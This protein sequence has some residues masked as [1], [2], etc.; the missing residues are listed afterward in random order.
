MVH[1]ELPATCGRVFMLVDVLD[2]IRGRRLAEIGCPTEEVHAG[3]LRQGQRGGHGGQK[4]AAEVVHVHPTGQIGDDLL[5][6]RWPVA[7]LCPHESNGFTGLVG[8]EISHHPHRFCKSNGEVGGNLCHLLKRFC[9]NARLDALS[10]E[11]GEFGRGGILPLPVQFDP[12]FL[13]VDVGQTPATARDFRAD[14]NEIRKPNP[15]F[16]RR[17]LP[18]LSHAHARGRRGRCSASG[19]FFH[20]GQICS[21]DRRKVGSIL[22]QELFG[23]SS[24]RLSPSCDEA[25]VFTGAHDQPSV[26]KGKRLNQPTFFRMDVAADHLH[27]FL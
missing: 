17:G 24:L 5:H 26:V 16:G 27:A 25:L 9:F 18:K 12:T 20:F 1:L 13:H 8:H 11:T 15:P 10:E 14:F 19:R 2:L 23:P 4:Q 3:F 21:G 7:F 6:A 22:N